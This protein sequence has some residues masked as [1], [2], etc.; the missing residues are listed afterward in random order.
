MPHILVLALANNTKEINSNQL[1]KKNFEFG[2]FLNP[3]KQCVA[4]YGYELKLVDKL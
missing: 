4:N 3:N 1:K 2:Q